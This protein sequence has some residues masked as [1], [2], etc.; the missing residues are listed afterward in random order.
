MDFLK[1]LGMQLP[2][3]PTI[4]VLGIHLKNVKTFLCK[5]IRTPMFT[6]ALCM[7]TKTWKQKMCPLID[8]WIMMM[9]YMYTMKYY[10]A[11]RKD[12]IL[13]LQQHRYIFKN[14]PNKMSQK[15]S[16]T[17]RFHSHVGY[18]TESNK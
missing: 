14:M 18:K 16:R 8:D 4:L 10:S 13:H 15:K 2:F 6:A 12:N 1:K 3:D 9:W 7:M 17:V 5:D 11:I